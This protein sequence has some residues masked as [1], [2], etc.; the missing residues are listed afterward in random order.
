[1]E[2]RLP[3]P[4]SDSTAIYP[5]KR[6]AITLQM[7]SPKPVPLAN[8][9]SFVKRL[10]TASCFSFGIPMPVSSTKICTCRSLLREFNSV[11]KKVGNHLCQPAYEVLR[12]PALKLGKSGK[13]CLLIH[14]ENIAGKR[15]TYGPI[16][17]GKDLRYH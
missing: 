11:A 4:I 7:D 17:Y 5:S 9:S 3:F 8:S 1:M 13:S 14:L 16:R 10:K 12:S 2:K 6:S 15:M